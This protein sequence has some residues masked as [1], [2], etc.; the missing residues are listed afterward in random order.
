MKRFFSGGPNRDN[1]L[2]VKYLPAPFT[3]RTHK[4]ERQET[5]FVGLGVEIFLLPK[6]A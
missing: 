2:S 5:A 4:T 6:Q 1:C 3:P